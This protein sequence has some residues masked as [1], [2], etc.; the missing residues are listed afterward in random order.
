MFLRQLDM[1]SPPITLYYKQKN[2][3]ASIISGILTICSL[4][5]ILSFVLVYFIKYIKRENP[6]VYLFN[7]YINDAGTFSFKDLNF[8]NYIEISEDITKSKK[9]LDF[10]KIEIIGI[11]ITMESFKILKNLDSI[12]HWVYGNC[13]NK[14]DI[15]K[16]S[17]LLNNETFNKS[18]CIKKFYNH[19]K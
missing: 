2:T 9:K 16:I 5:S 19:E 15:K 1:L 6:Q 13:D 18:A 7:K 8:F 4:I 14:I 10:N 12:S 17:Y 3:H 11:N